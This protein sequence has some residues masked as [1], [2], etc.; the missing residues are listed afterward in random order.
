MSMLGEE[1]PPR[2][3]ST[4]TPPMTASQ[5]PERWAVCMARGDGATPLVAIFFHEA[6]KEKTQTSLY[7]VRVVVDCGRVRSSSSIREVRSLFPSPPKTTTLSSSASNVAE[8]PHRAGGF[9]PVT[10]GVYQTGGSASV[11]ST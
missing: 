5:S 7:N 11:S 4:I 6:E 1:G 8:W 9:S 10:R 3:A 2:A